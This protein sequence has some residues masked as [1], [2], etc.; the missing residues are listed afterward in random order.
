[1]A[2]RGQYVVT[3]RQSRFYFL[4][5]LCAIFLSL[6]A[7]FSYFSGV[8]SILGSVVN[9]I[10]SPVNYGTAR[11][12]DSIIGVRDYFAN[13]KEL[14]EENLRLMSENDALLKEKAKNEAV[15]SENEELYAFLGLKKDFTDL[16]L[17][18]AKIISKSGSG[19][20][21]S[22]TIDKGTIH[23]VKKDMP[24]IADS[25]ILGIVSEEGLATSRCISLVS[26]NASVGVYFLRT[27]VP[28]ILEG[29]FALSKDGMCRITGLGADTD[30]VVGD[31]V[32]TSGYGEIFPK[33]LCVG[34]VNEIIRDATT[35][36]LAVTVTPSC[37]PD[38]IDSVM[39]ITDFERKYEETASLKK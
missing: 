9:I 6:L 27:G 16:S 37:N 11:V 35:H 21:T 32:Y 30:V 23:G 31:Y 17:V 38:R 14:K 20:M 12:V 13:V 26:H 39:V 18:N 19:F 10:L 5:M 15:R 4:S 7:L 33:D 25:G 1:M 24:V 29:D 34:K 28:G 8:S 36:T 2:Y 22:F 3:K